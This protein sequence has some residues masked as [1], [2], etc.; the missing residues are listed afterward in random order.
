MVPGG[1]CKAHVLALGVRCSLLKI[2]LR[3]QATSP[4]RPAGPLSH[5]AVNCVREEKFVGCG[6]VFSLLKLDLD[7]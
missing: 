6:H 3:I 5:G 7:A 1:R 4:I 2:P